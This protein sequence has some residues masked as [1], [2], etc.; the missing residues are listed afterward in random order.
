MRIRAT[1]RRW[2]SLVLVG[3]VGVIAPA[4]CGYN[5]AGR[6]SFLPSHIR[7][8]GVPPFDS[9]VPRAI[10]V[11]EIT[12]AVT[13]EFISRGGYKIVPAEVGADAVLKGSIIGFNETPIAFDSDGRA[14]R[15]VL[16]VSASVSMRDLHEARTL[17]ENP[18]FQFRVELELD[19][20]RILGDFQDPESD[21]IKVL[22]EEFAKTLV[23]T[24]VEGF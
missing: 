4:G 17:Y 12:S 6:G 3:V 21:A 7:T 18:A 22:S 24:V 1:L 11:E 19:T 2:C 13:R 9:I 16:S 23:A 8:I 10:V 15:S 5:L 14:T 20:E